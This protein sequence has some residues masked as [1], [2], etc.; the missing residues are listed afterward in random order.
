MTAIDDKLVAA[1]EVDLPCL[2][3]PFA[4]LAE[5]SG[6]PGISE[7][8]LIEALRRWLEEGV[9]RRYGAL[10]S[11]R[12]LGYRANAMIVWRAPEQRVEEIGQALARQPE[13]SHCYQRPPFEGFPYNLY[14]VVHGRSREECERIARRLSAQVGLDDYRILFSTREF[15]K[16]S[17]RFG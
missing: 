6:D 9:V 15:K 1:L 11:H 13:I 10:V 5:R 17:P 14:A 16:A 3:R 8:S 2:R 7:Q 12:A 4:A